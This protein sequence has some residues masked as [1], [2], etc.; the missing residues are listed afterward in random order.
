MWV[1]TP[2]KLNLRKW[3]GGSNTFSRFVFGCLGTSYKWSDNYNYISTIDI[4]VEV[5]SC[6]FFRGPLDH[7]RQR[8]RARCSSTTVTA[9]SA[10]KRLNLASL[11]VSAK[12]THTHFASACGYPGPPFFVGGPKKSPHFLVVASASF[13][14]I[15]GD[16][17]WRDV[18]WTSFL[19]NELT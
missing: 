19:V 8:R 1:W 4:P 6:W 16:K 10:R 15:M 7:F 13:I 5:I 18:F 12:W 3:L 17:G 9:L 14:Y 2:L 11:R